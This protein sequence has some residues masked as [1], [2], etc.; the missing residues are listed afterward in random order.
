MDDGQHADGWT[1]RRCAASQELSTRLQDYFFRP[2]RAWSSSCLTQSLWMS[3][4]NLVVDLKLNNLRFLRMTTRD[5]HRDECRAVCERHETLFDFQQSKKNPPVRATQFPKM[6]IFEIEP[7][8]ANSDIV[9]G[10]NYLEQHPRPQCNMTLLTTAITSHDRRMQKYPRR[11]TTASLTAFSCLVLFYTAC[12][13]T[14]YN[15]LPAFP[16]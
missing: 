3:C 12:G 14:I 16:T 6:S 8:I 11:T 15:T 2:T 5:L 7:P 10:K 1:V 13:V 4:H 9:S